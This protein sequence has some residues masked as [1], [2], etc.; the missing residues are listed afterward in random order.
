MT[1]ALAQPALQVLAAAGTLF[2]FTW[3]FLV[4]DRPVHVFVSFFF[5][6]L[7]VIA[8]LLLFSR[9]GEQRDAEALE[10]EHDEEKNA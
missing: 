8:L 2:A 4:F 9:A 7:A 10:F 6:W 5:L 3:P 1:R